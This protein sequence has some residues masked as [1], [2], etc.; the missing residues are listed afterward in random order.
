MR[1][2]FNNQCK[3]LAVK[4]SDTLIDNI[5]EL[6]KYMVTALPDSFD[7]LRLILS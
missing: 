1:C 7:S 3:M 2:L 4:N 6:V 5:S